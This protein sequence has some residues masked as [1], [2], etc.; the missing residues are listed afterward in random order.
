MHWFIIPRCPHFKKNNDMTPIDNSRREFLKKSIVAVAAGSAAPYFS[1]SARAFANN[2]PNDRPHIG[3]IGVGNL[4]TS[5]D[6]PK[7]AEFAD[8]LAVRDVDRR[9]AEQ[10]QKDPKIGR[11]KAD[12]YS[13]YRKA[14]EWKDVD[15]L[16]IATPDHWHVKIAIEAL[17]AGK[18]VFCQKPL[19][20][21]LEENQLI[22]SAC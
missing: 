15:V 6:C 11:G 19:T 2:A 18:H 9:W 1:W 10:A 14:L 16:S 8:I 7:H 13:D 20:L 12:A 5:T 21:T 17:Q 4:A 22:R 3:C